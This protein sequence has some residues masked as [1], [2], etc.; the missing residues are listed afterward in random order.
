MIVLN[1]LIHLKPNRE[2]EYLRSV[3]KLFENSRCNIC[4]D[5]FKRTY[6]PRKFITIDYRSDDE[7]IFTHYESEHFQSFL[8][9][10]NEFLEEPIDFKK[11]I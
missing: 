7:A 8:R 6:E 11:D 4:Y 9:E 5:I 2:E 3:N 1:V 10:V